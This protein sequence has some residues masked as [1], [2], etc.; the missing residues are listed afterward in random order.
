MVACRAE[1]PEPLVGTSQDAVRGQVAVLGRVELLNQLG[2]RV[3]HR[4]SAVN[5]NRLS[6]TCITTLIPFSSVDDSV[7]PFMITG[8]AYPPYLLLT[9]PSKLV[10]SKITV[11]SWMELIR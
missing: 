5:V 2:V 10:W 8:L 4:V 7:L 3:P 11:L 6:C 1:P 9:P